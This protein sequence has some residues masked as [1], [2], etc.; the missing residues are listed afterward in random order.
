L[1]PQIATTA[2]VDESAQVIGDVMLGE[3]VSIWPGA[4]LRGDMNYIR[5]GDYTN[6][7]DLCLVHVEEGFSPTV[8][9]DHITV[10]HSVI[11]H[12]CYV[13][14]RCLIAMGAII[15]SGARIGTG[16]V[17]A[18]G[19]LVPEGAIIPPGS[20]VMGVPGKVRREV[21]EAELQRIDQGAEAYCRWKERYVAD[22][23][24][25]VRGAPGG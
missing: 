8:L 23:G 21:T 14:R 18:A 11:L 22:L 16:S 1:R 5:V 13:E 15:L 7:Q 6:I 10:G 9:E 2:Y 3:H 20:L 4:V 24:R 17:V 19:S 25:P 12:G